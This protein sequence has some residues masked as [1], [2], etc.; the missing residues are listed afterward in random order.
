MIGHALVLTAGLGTRL[1]PLTEVRAKPAIPVAGEPMIRRIIRTL[2]AQGITDLVLNLHHLPSTLTSV[3]GDGGDLGAAVRYSWEPV[4]LGSAGGP[5]LARPIVG[6]ASFW[7]INGDTLTDVSCAALAERHAASGAR[8]TLALVRNRE[9]ERY[10]GVHLDGDGRVTRF[11]RRG[12]SSE[13]SY[14]YIGVQLVDGGVFDAVQPGEA[15]SSI[16]GVYDALIASDP[17]AVRGFVCDAAFFD[18]GTVDDY[19]RTDDAFR[20]IAA[21][22]PTPSIGRDTTIDPSARVTRSILWDDV[23]VGAGATLDECIVTDAV[24]VPAGGGYTRSVLLR[25]DD[26]QPIIVPMSES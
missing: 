24:T 23:R 13:G 18:V 22:D 3:V 15:A 5:R 1:R 7:I 17:G 21:G 8:V 20:G 26:E 25:G 2:A 14:H 19:R 6:A 12:P 9:Y 11:T 4:I 10:G 16:G